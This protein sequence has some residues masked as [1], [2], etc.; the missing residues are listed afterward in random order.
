MR[1]YN[2]CLSLSDLF[3]LEKCPQGPCPSILLQMARFHSLLWLNNILL[4]IYL[5]LTFSLSIHPGIDTHI[6][7]VSRLMN[8][9]AMNIGV[10]IYF[11]V[12]VFISFG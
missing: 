2:I 7:S 11:Q 12:S 3:H 9:A 5:P 4:S 1:S 8:N 6:V 10:Q